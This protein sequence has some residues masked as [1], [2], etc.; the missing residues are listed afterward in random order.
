MTNTWTEKND[1]ITANKRKRADSVIARC[2]ISCALK[3]VFILHLANK[4]LSL[5]NLL[6][7]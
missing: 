6:W 5:N 7:V 1:R 4:H 2:E 3:R